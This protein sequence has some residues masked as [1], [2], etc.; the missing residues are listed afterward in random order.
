MG[1]LNTTSALNFMRSSLHLQVVQDFADA[2][3]RILD[4][5]LTIDEVDFE[6]FPN[7]AAPTGAPNPPSNTS[8]QTPS[9]IDQK[10][11]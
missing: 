7:P 6:E 2:G 4:A 1:P 8:N 5:K 11:M 10:P 9:R 3:G